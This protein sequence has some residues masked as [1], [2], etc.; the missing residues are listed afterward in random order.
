MVIIKRSWSFKFFIGAII[1]FSTYFIEEKSF[2]S[3][4]SSLILKFK[5][6]SKDNL[7]FNGA[8]YYSQQG[9]VLEFKECSFNSINSYFMG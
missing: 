8:C 7:A 3:V 2:F 6:F 1:A 4:K 9:A 5:L